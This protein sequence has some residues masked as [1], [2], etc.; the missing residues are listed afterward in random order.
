MGRQVATVLSLKKSSQGDCPPKSALADLRTR[1]RGGIHGAIGGRTLRRCSCSQLGCRWSRLVEDSVTR[2]EQEFTQPDGVRYG[3][4]FW[5]AANS[6][7]LPRSSELRGS[8]AEATRGVWASALVKLPFNPRPTRTNSSG[9]TAIT[10]APP[11]TW[12]LRKPDP[13]ADSPR[14]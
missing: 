8:A 5:Y 13:P 4:S 11:G 6:G 7:L 2:M 14:P 10:I 1:L 3:E 12:P 9:A